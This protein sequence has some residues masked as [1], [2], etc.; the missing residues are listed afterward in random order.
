MMR[1]ISYLKNCCHSGLGLHDAM[2]LI[3]LNKKPKNYHVSSLCWVAGVMIKLRL[4]ILF[5]DKTPPKNDAIM[6]H[7]SARVANTMER[8]YWGW[9][10][11]ARIDIAQCARGLTACILNFDFWKA[12]VYSI[13]VLD[14][15]QPAVYLRPPTQSLK[16]QHIQAV[17]RYNVN[18]IL[19][20]ARLVVQRETLSRTTYRSIIK[21]VLL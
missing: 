2:M 6:K 10:V 21:L 17:F 4:S 15:R 13:E 11:F 20:T 18:I 19:A 5:I 16:G 8:V 9:T 1:R 14:V 12:N 7:N 3:L